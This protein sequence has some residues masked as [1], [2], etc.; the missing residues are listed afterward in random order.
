M[1]NVNIGDKVWFQEIWSGLLQ[2]GIVKKVGTASN[3]EPYAEI[4]WSS[5]GTSSILLENLYPT[6]N[7]L[8]KAME[9]KSK[10]YI[11]DVKSNIQDVND[12]IRF[13]YD[14]PIATSSGEYTNYDARRVVRERAK[15]LL[16]LD[17]D[18]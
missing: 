14:T 17:L 16:N 11:A 18:I 3:H 6:K 13:M 9:Q 12:L 2:S 15:E 10:E 7:A 1:K 5:G 4:N 8:V